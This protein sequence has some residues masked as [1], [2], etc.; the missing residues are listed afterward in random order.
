MN[1]WHRIFGVSLAD[2]VTGL[3][4]RVIQELEL[5]QIKQ[6]LDVAIIRADRTLPTAHWPDMPDGLTDLADHNIVTYKSIRESLSRAAMYELISSSVLYA[7]QEWKDRDWQA[8]FQDDG[9]MR[10]MAVATLRPNWLNSV[11]GPDLESTLPG[12][13]EVHGFQLSIRVIVP[14]EVQRIARNAFWHLL[15][16][17]EPSVAFG[18]EHYQMHDATLYNI[19]NDLKRVYS[20][21]GIE[22]PYTVDD[23]KREVAREL[24]KSMS[25]K[26]R[27]E[28]ISPRERL[29]GISPSERLEGIPPR[30]RL[31]GMTLQERLEGMSVEEIERF[32][33]QRSGTQG[34]NDESN[35][36][37]ESA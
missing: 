27:L 16:G 6:R 30:D 36:G 5:A 8:A 29:E 12:I 33:K 31:E 7:K 15:S 37:N 4:F 28:G 17:H 34:K 23:Y 32:L 19:L 35:R 14:R 25:P 2:A 21:E 11:D 1:D 20:L 10:L 22:V 13:Y 3:P 24:L 9:R 18:L 26:E